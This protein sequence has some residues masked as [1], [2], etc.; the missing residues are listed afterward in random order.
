MK[1]LYITYDGLL[2]P[3]GSSQILP[4]LYGL[5]DSSK[6]IFI[7][8]VE[9]PNRYKAN[10]KSLRN[11]LSKKNIYWKPLLFS[12]QFGVL[13]KLWDFYK[14]YYSAI[15]LSAFY[16][17]DAVHARGHV[18]A[19]VA[20]FLKLFLNIKFIFDFRGLW[21]D[22][23]VDKGGWNLDKTFDR[24]QYKFFK[25][26][27]KKLLSH[28]DHTIVLTNKVVK[29]VC[30]ISDINSNQITVIPCC[31]D[32]EHFSVQT[33]QTKAKIKK[34]LEISENSLVFGY[35]GSVG[36]MYLL[37]DYLRFIELI[38][39]KYQSRDIDIF[40][41]IITNDLQ[42]AQDAKNNILPIDLKEKTL[43]LSASR[44]EVP[45]LLHSLD[46]LISF[47]TS[48]YA[49]QGASP[50]KIAESFACGIPIISNKG[51]GDVEDQVNAI[52]GGKIINDT[53]IESLKKII[54]DL[55]QILL[56]DRKKIRSKAKELLSLNVAIGRYKDVYS[57]INVINK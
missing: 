50:T 3:L 25:N 34:Q 43:V 30:K 17:I 57:K 55:D 44:E 21:V 29:E 2:D 11:E 4:Y 41:L 52:N 6:F 15:K 27:E 32:F 40:G 42:K 51:I 18:A 46:V 54:L 19:Q 8:S 26:K 22:E 39:L 16:R 12:K 1:V 53:S 13:G 38:H 49:R 28:A 31:A 7:I 33:K 10:Y 36:S 20:S 45:K 14:M 47:I 5:N 24:A 48:T 23:R 35:L 56:L 9:K 37:E